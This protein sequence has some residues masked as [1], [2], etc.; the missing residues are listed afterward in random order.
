[1]GGVVVMVVSVRANE[2][3]DCFFIAAVA[4]LAALGIFITALAMAAHEKKF[5]REAKNARGEVVNYKTR[6]YGHPLIEFIV[7]GQTV[8]AA[9]GAKNMDY[10]THPK[11]TIVRI[12]YMPV[13]WLGKRAYKI[14][15]DEPGFAPARN[16][17]INI[18]MFLSAVL[19]LTA[20]L[21]TVMG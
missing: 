12:R 17:A 15:V 20:V 13:P 14:V 4:A 9:A 5:R 10:N 7:D 3:I 2:Y 1:M 6:N 18:F 19:F 11:G 16:Y 21:F 8:V